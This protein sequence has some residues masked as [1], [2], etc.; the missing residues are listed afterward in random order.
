[1]KLIFLSL[2]SWLVGLLT[3]LFAD[4]S[5]TA[6]GPLIFVALL[7]ALSY[8]PFL[9][10]LRNRLGGCR[11]FLL[12]PLASSLLLNLPVFFIG[13]LAIGRT[14]VVSEAFAFVGA[15]IL[16]G[17][18]FGAGFVWNYHDQTI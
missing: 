8:G 17:L 5:V 7:F 4:L 12:F 2:G 18:V 16:M 10:W 9:T 14:L 11:P 15:F 3:I 6:L 1:M 13:I